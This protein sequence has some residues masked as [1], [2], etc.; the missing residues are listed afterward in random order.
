LNGDDTGKR[1]AGAVAA[2]EVRSGCRVP[3]R[4][5]TVAGQYSEKVM[6]HPFAHFLVWLILINL[7]ATLAIVVAIRLLFRRGMDALDI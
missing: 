6:H 1:S 2:S 4:P 7:G 5:D 3:R